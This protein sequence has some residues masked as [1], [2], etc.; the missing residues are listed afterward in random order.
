MKRGPATGAGA[1]VS[2][3]SAV[4]AWGE[5]LPD[6]VEMLARMADRSSQAAVGREIGYSGSV[7]NA[8]L[9][10]SY[11]GALASVEKTVR[12]RFMLTAAIVDDV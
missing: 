6:W 3:T 11:N 2:M 8:V 4:A 1:G 5:D 10:R 12:G 9:K 7:V